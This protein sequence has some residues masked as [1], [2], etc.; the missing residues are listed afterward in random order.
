MQHVHARKGVEAN[1]RIERAAIVAG[2]TGERFLGRKCFHYREP[3]SC[4]SCRFASSSSTLAA[5]GAEKLCIAACGRMYLIECKQS[6]TQTVAHS[7]LQNDLLVSVW[8]REHSLGVLLGEP[9]FSLE[10][11]FLVLIV[12]IPCYFSP[13]ANWV[14]LSTQALKRAR[15]GQKQL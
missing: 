10:C 3:L 9:F 5:A 13:V 7:F 8:I 12:A 15:G 1:L 4:S 2:R 11:M 14:C 6:S